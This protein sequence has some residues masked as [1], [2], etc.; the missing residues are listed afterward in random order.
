[1]CVC[2]WGGGARAMQLDRWKSSIS[3]CCCCCLQADLGDLSDKLAGAKCVLPSTQLHLIDA[4]R[5]L[6]SE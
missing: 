2:V 6:V 5:N 4:F 3:C 1:V